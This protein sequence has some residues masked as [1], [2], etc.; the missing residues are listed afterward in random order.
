[1][2]DNDLLCLL[3]LLYSLAGWL[4]THWD[5]SNKRC[6]K[7][8]VIS[9]QISADI[10]HFHISTLDNVWR[11]RSRHC[12]ELFFKTYIT[13]Q[14]IACVKCVLLGKR[15]SL[16]LVRGGL[17]AWRD[18]KRLHQKSVFFS[19]EHWNICI[20]IIKKQCIMYLTPVY[21]RTELWYNTRKQGKYFLYFLIL[22]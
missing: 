22:C 12:L 15:V 8:F 14:E 20:C 9:A 4:P 3:V 19:R 16:V 17:W 11:I 18:T 10:S 1:M 6:F 5:T 13:Q 7:T 21:W 2:H